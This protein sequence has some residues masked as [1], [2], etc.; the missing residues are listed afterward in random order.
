MVGPENP[1][2]RHVPAVGLAEHPGHHPVGH[3][4]CRLPAPHFQWGIEVS[5]LRPETRLSNPAFL[6]IGPIPVT[7]ALLRVTYSPGTGLPP[8][9]GPAASPVE[10]RYDRLYR[11]GFR[12]RAN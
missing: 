9:P 3:Q 11:G 5:K 10:T 7:H 8:H 4:R 6:G 12:L 2:R 1:L